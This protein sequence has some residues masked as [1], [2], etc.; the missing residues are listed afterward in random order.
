YP[1][2]E[3]KRGPFV[4]RAEMWRRAEPVLAE[5]GLRVQPRQ[6]L[7]TLSL[8]ERQLVEVA[9]ALV[10]NPRV[11][12]LDEPTSALETA[13]TENLL[14]V[15]RVLRERQTAV[16]FVSHILDEV[17]AVCDEI[18]VLRDGR[19]VMEGASPAKLTVAEVVEAMLG[20]RERSRA[21]GTT[22]WET[23]QRAVA[24]AVEKA[25]SAGE[26]AGDVVL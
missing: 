18:T 24:A 9:K 8:A 5:L 22:T 16:V 10:T 17:M 2:R 7:A 19:V 1:M 15:L 12:I 11:L 6:Q 4:D 25:S 13:S 26:G 23:E 14:E 20:E 21:E 3:P